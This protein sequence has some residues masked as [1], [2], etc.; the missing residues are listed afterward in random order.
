MA[1]D[2]N[3][4]AMRERRKKPRIS[5]PFPTR[6]RGTDTRGEAFEAEGVLDNFSSGGLYIRLSQRVMEQAKL[7]F[8]IR[9]SGPANGQAPTVEARGIVL[10]AEAKP[11]GILGLAV[12]LTHHRF[13]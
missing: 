4:G 6:V 10:R 11:G 9:M 12:K 5:T 2:S 7:E 8:L 1:K 13:M 3:L